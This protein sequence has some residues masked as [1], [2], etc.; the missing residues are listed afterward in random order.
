MTG[1]SSASEHPCG[2]I[3]HPIGFYPLGFAVMCSASDVAYDGDD[4][5]HDEQGYPSEAQKGQKCADSFTGELV[6][7]GGIEQIMDRHSG[8]SRLAL[9]LIGK[10]AV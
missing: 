6:V 3:L 9:H 4:K 7:N 5:S 8:P 10:A 1:K 2:E